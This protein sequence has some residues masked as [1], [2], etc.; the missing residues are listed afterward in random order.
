MLIS[1]Y[2]LLSVLV[3]SSFAD[4][5][6]LWSEVD[7]K[8]HH[9]SL[10]DAFVDGAKY[11]FHR[12]SCSAFGCDEW[13][14]E[15]RTSCESTNDG[16]SHAKIEHFNKGQ[17]FSREEFSEFEWNRINGN[18]LRGTAAK[19]Q[20]LGQT[21]SLDRVTESA[22]GFLRADYTVRTGSQLR[23]EGYWIL[24]DGPAIPQI[25]E[26]HSTRYGIFKEEDTQTYVPGAESF[27]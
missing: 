13:N 19:A 21:F 18:F 1:A 14:Y 5:P 15:V 25:I 23:E 10:C 24:G 4:S 11:V 9:E 17:V 22:E 2:L 6:D 7:A 20:M 27:K 16:T 26:R 12:R 3:S 8:L